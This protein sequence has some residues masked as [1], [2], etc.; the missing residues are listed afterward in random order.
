MRI[1]RGFTLIE[2]SIGV[3]ISAI[4]LVG[5]MNL[6]S[7]GMR[8][9]TKGLAH[10]ANMESASILMSQIEYDL[11]RA[12]EIIEPAEDNKSNNG[13]WKFYYA[14]SAAITGKGD[15]VTVQYNTNTG[16]GCVR[17]VDMG[18]GKTQNT[19]LA[20]GQKVD[21]SFAHFTVNNALKKYADKKL[22]Q[23]KH[24]VWVELTVSSKYGKKIGK[25]DKELEPFTLKKLIVI[26]SQL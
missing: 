1:R 20:K 12:T 6:F 18:D 10:Q 24:A 19:V 13:S 25:G 7:S 11:L 8:G 23:K 17:Y 4:I 15:P 21:L 16:D 2:V 22:I 14:A 26:R 3:I 5:L 9:S